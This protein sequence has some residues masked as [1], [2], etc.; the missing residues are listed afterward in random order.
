MLHKTLSRFFLI[1]LAL[2]APAHAEQ[3][4]G[5]AAAGDEFD[6][7]FDDFPGSRDIDSSAKFF[8]GWN[9]MD[10]WSVEGSYHNFGD[11]ACCDRGAADIGIDVEVEGFSLGVVYAPRF[12]RFAP[13]AKLGWFSA[14]IEGTS[15]T[16]AGPRDFDDSDSGL[17]A[18]VGL[19]WFVGESFALR[20]GYE[21]F[22][23]EESDSA[24]NLG[25]EIH[26]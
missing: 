11:A 23:F 26:F 13:F 20:A 4:Y 9:F 17:M 12:E 3:F 1:A 6:A 19:R 15:L 2:S 8:L 22:D 7:R 14:D 21:W 18:E 5:G 24:V 25:A 16:I 10:S